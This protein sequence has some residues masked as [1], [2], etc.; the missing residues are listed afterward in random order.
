MKNSYS[1][2]ALHGLEVLKMKGALNA[3]DQVAQ[4]AAAE[5]W[6]YTQFLGKLMEKELAQRMQN[7]ID[8]NLQMASF[9]YLKTIE[10]YDFKSQPSVDKRIIEELATG[11]YLDE[12]RCLIF[13]GPPGVGKTHLAI[14]LA[15]QACSQGK[16]ASFISCADLVRKLKLALE[17]N[18]LHQELLKFTR[19]KVLLIDEVGYLELNKVEASLLFQVISKRY[20]LNASIILTSNKH[21]TNWGDIFANDSIMAAAALDRLLH[22]STIINIKGESYRLKEK[23]IAEINTS[24]EKEKTK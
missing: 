11:R 18:R 22:K 15:A 21:F 9:P 12:G 8:M 14:A 2:I 3:L 24:I 17:E 23:K 6:S 4:Q 1:E 19:T 5:R 16:K 13:L 7:L 10:G 20:D